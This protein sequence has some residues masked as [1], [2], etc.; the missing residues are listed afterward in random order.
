MAKSIQKK[1]NKMMNGLAHTLFEEIETNSISMEA[2]F[3][4]RETSHT[5]HTQSVP[6]VPRPLLARLAAFKEDP[7][8]ASGLWTYSLGRHG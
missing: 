5:F 4:R 3:L 6:I 8:V 7:S 2:D 1:Q